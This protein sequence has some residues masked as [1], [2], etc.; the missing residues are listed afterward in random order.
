MKF[1]HILLVAMLVA[2]PLGVITAAAS[3]GVTPP[4]ASSRQAVLTASNPGSEINV[5]TAPTTQ[6]VAPYFGLVGDRVQIL[7]EARGN[8]GY[9]WYYV[10]FNSKV[11]KGWVRQDLVRFNATDEGTVAAN[12]QPP[13]IAPQ[14][15]S[16]RLEVPPTHSS[17]STNPSRSVS[18]YSA[19]QIDY[20]L[21]VALGNEFGGGSARI[22]KWQGPI[23]IKVNGSPTAEDSRTLQQ[24][25]NEINELANGAV[26]LA[27]DDNNP[28]VQ[29]YFVPES[30]F[31]RYEPNYRP[32]NLGFFWARW[33]QNIIQNSNILITTT[34]VTQKE[35]SHL[36]REELT[37]TL[38]LMK[39]SYRYRDSIFYQGWTDPTEYSEIDRAVVQMLYLPKI[40]P[41][42][43]RA[44]VVAA[45]QNLATTSKPRTSLN[46]TSN[47]SSTPI[48]VEPPLNFSF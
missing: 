30:Q 23:R 45:M 29:I 37:Q 16:S 12:P 48:P 22:K 28:N 20:F 17:S 39:D 14:P 10:K 13:Q 15:N 19:E 32:R 26:Q 11:G 24:V 3:I 25:I 35:R 4:I 34:G 42:M 8:D 7:K 46:Q 44:E 40:R 27:V 43:T 38:G 5:R 2:I 18:P 6:S 31:K 36:I 33:N 1:K 47:Q 9:T 21:E 41:G